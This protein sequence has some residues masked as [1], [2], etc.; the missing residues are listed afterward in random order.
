MSDRTRPRA[1]GLLGRRRPYVLLGQLMVTASLLL[2]HP[3]VAR[4]Y[5]GL[6][7]GFATDCGAIQAPSVA[8][9]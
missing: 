7:A 1:G 2:M 9:M 5:G 8:Y 6:T 3:R 4:S